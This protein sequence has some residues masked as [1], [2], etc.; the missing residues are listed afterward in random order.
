MKLKF[1]KACADQYSVPKKSDQTQQA[2][3]VKSS[4]KSQKD[5]LPEKEKEKEEEEKNASPFG[6]VMFHFM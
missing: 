3:P 1:V 6:L 5:A 2:Q 4:N